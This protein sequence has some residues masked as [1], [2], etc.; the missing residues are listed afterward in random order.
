MA[1][2]FAGSR[3]QPQRRYACLSSF[4][5]KLIA[6]SAM[7]TDHIGCILYPDAVWLRCIGRLAFPLFVFMLTEGASHT[8]SMK[9]YILRMLVFALITE[10]PYNLAFNGTLLYTGSRNMLFTLTLGLCMIYM[11]RTPLAHL[12]ADRESRGLIA[13]LLFGTAAELLRTESGMMGILLIYLC[14]M[15]RDRHVL[16]YTLSEIL[17]IVWGGVQPFAGFAFIPMEL[18]TGRRGFS[19]RLLQ[20][21]FY[22]FYPAHLFVLY[23]IA[24]SPFFS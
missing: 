22:A 23:L 10:I 16:K 19:S 2:E 3:K 6:I 13:L 4:A 5:I 20:Y 24:Q 1:A 9:R 18:Y 21:L 12:P 11:I 15:F 8:H 7:L 14:C 17:F